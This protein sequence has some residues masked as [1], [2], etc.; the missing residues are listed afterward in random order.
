MP[1]KKRVS[2][3]QKPFSVERNKSYNFNI[4][5]ALEIEVTEDDSIQATSELTKTEPELESEC[6]AKTSLNHE[7]ENGIATDSK[8]E[9]SDSEATI[10]EDSEIKVPLSE[11]KMSHEKSCDH[12]DSESHNE[13]IGLELQPTISSGGSSH[14]TASLSDLVGPDHNEDDSEYEDLTTNPV[15]SMLKQFIESDKPAEQKSDESSNVACHNPNEGFDGSHLQSTPQQIQSSDVEEEPSILAAP[16]EL[17]RT[18]NSLSPMEKL[19]ISPGIIIEPTENEFL[20]QDVEA[21]ANVEDQLVALDTKVDPRVDSSIV[22]KEKLWI[23][24]GIIIEPTENEFLIRDLK[25]F[26]NSEDQPL[27]LDTKS[28]LVVDNSMV[29]T[30]KLWISPGIIIEPT[31]NEFL[32]QD[33][34]VCVDV[35]DQP[36]VPY[37]KSELEIN[38]CTDVDDQN[39]SDS[40]DMLLG[41]EES[42]E[43]F[44]LAE[45]VEM[46]TTPKPEEQSSTPEFIGV[47]IDEM[48]QKEACLNKN[49]N[50]SDQE[51][52]N[53]ELNDEELL[54]SDSSHVEDS[55]I[56]SYPTPSDISTIIGTASIASAQDVECVKRPSPPPIMSPVNGQSAHATSYNGEPVY[57]AVAKFCFFSAIIFGLKALAYV[58]LGLADCLAADDSHQLKPALVRGSSS[59]RDE[60]LA[61][62]QTAVRGL[63]KADSNDRKKSRFMGSPSDVEKFISSV[64]FCSRAIALAIADSAAVLFSIFALATV[65]IWKSIFNMDKTPLLVSGKSVLHYGMQTGISL[66]ILAIGGVQWILHTTIDLIHGSHQPKASGLARSPKKFGGHQKRIR[67]GSFSRRRR[68]ASEP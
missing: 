17:S 53:V 30:E 57:G 49:S 64:F 31:K 47:Q 38:H 27:A 11:H 46:S 42:A 16:Q 65:E 35:K 63:L 14:V 33:V 51:K 54:R 5:E 9:G 10:I 39:T 23:S 41:G 62:V 37:T 32:V 44:D 13:K 20:A 18:G 29:S 2:Q 24:P 36:F 15:L 59:D 55:T 60:M 50:V 21:C 52:F 4:Y 43:R 66:C 26:V 12:L 6:N 68:R 56:L 58:L 1:V 22:S 19:W 61:D 8:V 25:A 34:Q 28:D 45:I 48:D 67:E 7:L 40:S 3:G